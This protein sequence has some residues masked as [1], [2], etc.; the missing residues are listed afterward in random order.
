MDELMTESVGTPQ[1]DP[2]TSVRVVDVTFRS[3]GK[4]Y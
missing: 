1:P 4:V 2:N 3:G